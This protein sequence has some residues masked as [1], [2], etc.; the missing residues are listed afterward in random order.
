MRNSPSAFARL[1]GI[2][3]GPSGG[4]LSQR[5]AAGA[6]NM[7]TGEK[8]GTSAQD[9]ALMQGGCVAVPEATADHAWEGTFPLSTGACPCSRSQIRTTL[10]NGQLREDNLANAR[11]RCSCSGIFA[12]IDKRTTTLMRSLR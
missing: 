1:S 2:V 8:R 4:S 11:D 3:G 10:D 7:G 12:T 6:E 5:T 9:S